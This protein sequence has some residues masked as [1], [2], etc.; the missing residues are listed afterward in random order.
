M[1]NVLEKKVEEGKVDSDFFDGEDA[2]T[3][4]REQLGYTSQKEDYLSKDLKELRK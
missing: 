4:E 2:V 1:I 3:F